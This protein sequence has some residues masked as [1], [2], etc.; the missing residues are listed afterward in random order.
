MPDVFVSYS[1]KRVFLISN[2]QK[3]KYSISGTKRAFEKKQ[4]MFF[5]VS[6]MLSF[7][8][9]GQNSKNM[10]DITFKDY[11]HLSN[12][13]EFLQKQPLTASEL[14]L[15]IGATEN[16][17]ADIAKLEWKNILSVSF[18]LG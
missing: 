4:K 10:S 6:K 15:L 11:Y 5:P 13:N 17:F 9:K 16:G 14:K 2:I 7:R 8:P 12:W 1:V 18:W 3:F